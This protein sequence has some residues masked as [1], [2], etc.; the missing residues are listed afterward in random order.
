[1]R[2]IDSNELKEWVKNWFEKHR[3]YHPYSKANDIPIT[4]L[5]D[6]LGQMPTV[7]A[8]PVVRC[9]DCKWFADGK[10][11]RNPNNDMV[12]GGTTGEWFCGDGKRKGGAE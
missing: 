5:Y 3:Y 1:M 9:R 10:W 4:E 2:L 7:D 11:C 8:E 12:Q 6:L